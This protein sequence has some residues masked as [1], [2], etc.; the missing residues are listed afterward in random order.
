M[1]TDKIKLLAQRSAAKRTGVVDSSKSCEVIDYCNT[2][3]YTSHMRHVINISVPEVLKREV[4]REAKAG[5]YVSVSE[6]FRA[7]MRER[8]ENLILR[9][10]E[11][12]RREFFSG[13]VKN[14]RSLKDLQ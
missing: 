5:G 3:C 14:L 2:L 1:S 4:E 11:E 12:G 7:V 10:V 6:F 9:D 13:K 8:K